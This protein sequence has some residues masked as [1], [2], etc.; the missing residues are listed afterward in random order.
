MRTMNEQELADLLDGIKGEGRFKLFGPG[1]HTYP[2]RNSGEDFI[3]YSCLELEA[4]GLIE[5]NVVNPGHVSWAA[6]DGKFSVH[7][8]GV[9]ATAASLVAMAAGRAREVT[10]A[11]I[12]STCK[13]LEA[14]VASCEKQIEGYRRKE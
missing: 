1:M 10:S 8:D 14:S 11:E 9:P 12:V 4:R 7:I 2:G 6:V 3:Y 13:R 5:R